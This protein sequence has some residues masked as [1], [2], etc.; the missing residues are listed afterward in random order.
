V[1]AE[2]RIKKGSA[3]AR[4]EGKGGSWKLFVDGLYRGGREAG[5]ERG[6]ERDTLRFHRLFLRRQVQEKEDFDGGG[7]KKIQSGLALGWYG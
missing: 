1:S 2:A 3:I 5:G 7:G 6:K 4:T